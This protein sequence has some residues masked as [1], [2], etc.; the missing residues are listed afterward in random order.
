M[1][2]VVEEPEFVVFAVCPG[3]ELINVPGDDTIP[4]WSMLL[5]YTNISCIYNKITCIGI[6]IDIL[7]C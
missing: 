3:P 6:G 5:S 4:V 1:T 7:W 2:L